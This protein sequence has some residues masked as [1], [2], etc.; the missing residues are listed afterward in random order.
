MNV[1]ISIFLGAPQEIILKPLDEAFSGFI[2][3]DSIK[4]EKIDK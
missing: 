1:I 3:N 4:G 2:V